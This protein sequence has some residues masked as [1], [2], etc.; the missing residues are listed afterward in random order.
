[1]SASYNAG[2]PPSRVVLVDPASLLDYVA[3]GSGPGDNTVT[4]QGE[5]VELPRDMAPGEKAP[6]ML[7]KDGML[8]V[9]LAMFQGADQPYGTF[10]QPLTFSQLK[11][12]YQG[13]IASGPMA[14]T[15]NTAATIIGAFPDRRGMRVLNYIAAPVYLSL[16][17]SGTPSS[18][19][20]SDYIPAAVG[21][22]PG[23]WEPPYAPV[24]G[25]RAVCATAGSITVTVW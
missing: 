20:G 14:L 19:A 3:G 8:L 6:L 10:E 13:N 22:V 12:G 15:A 25:V 21:G 11:A 16:G 7:N 4:S 2:S 18:G 5:Y 1:M 17:T 24:G 23:Q 9:N